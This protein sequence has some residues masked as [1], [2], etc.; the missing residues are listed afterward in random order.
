MGTRNR[1]PKYPA[2]LCTFDPSI[3]TPLRYFS[4]KEAFV[5]CSGYKGNNRKL[6]CGGYSIML[7]TY[8]NFLYQLTQTPHLYTD[9][10]HAFLLEYA[11][12]TDTEQLMQELSKEKYTNIKI[13]TP[14][15]V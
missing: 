8:D 1:K 11:P 9:Y 15:P 6:F 2:G 7:L 4:V 12:H 3:D 13:N 5:R 14:T 10:I